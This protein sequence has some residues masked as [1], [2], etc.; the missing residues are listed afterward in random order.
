MSEPDCKDL[1]NATLV[2]NLREVLL[3]GVVVER[4]VRPFLLRS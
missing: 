4:V 1:R 2:E 3:D